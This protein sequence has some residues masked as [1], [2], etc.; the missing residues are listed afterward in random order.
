MKKHS[1]KTVLLWLSLHSLATAGVAGAGGGI[2]C[3]PEPTD[4]QVEYGDVVSCSLGTSGDTDIFRFSGAA[5]EAVT[6]LLSRTSGGTPCLDLFGPT[7]DPIDSACGADARIDA[8][9]TETGSHTMLISESGGSSTAD[10]ALALERVAPPSAGATPICNGCNITSSLTPRGDLDLFSF[11]GAAGEVFTAILSRISGGIPCLDLFDPTGVI[12]DTACSA[13]G[14]RIDAT[15]GTSGTY[16]MLVSEFGVGSGINYALAL[17]RVA[18]PSG[19]A[20]AICPGCSLG[21]HIDPI[22]DL[23]L[24]YFLGSSGDVITV[25]A[26]QSFGGAPCVELFDPFGIQADS[27]CSAD[28]ARIDTTLTEDGFHSILIREISGGSQVE[29]EI[30]YLCIAGVCLDMG[31]VFFDGFESG[32]TSRWSS[33]QSSS[34]KR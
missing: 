22:G 32:D 10:Y 25:I 24:Y 11:D 16:T 5:G 27:A 18:P 19:N 9:L 13:T 28:S 30:T 23:D 29:Y 20:V 34:G 1:S 8:T 2:V 15:L 12:I 17:E 6:V 21:G 26:T 7:G 14:A 33:G 4:M 31:P 3:D